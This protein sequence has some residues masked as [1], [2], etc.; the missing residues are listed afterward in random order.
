MTLSVGIVCSDG[1]LLASDTLVEKTREFRYSSHLSKI[2]T[3]ANHVIAAACAGTE[4]APLAARLVVSEIDPGKFDSSTIIPELERTALKALRIEFGAIFDQLKEKGRA[5]QAKSLLLVATHGSI[6]R[7]EICSQPFV[8]RTFSG[9]E[10]AGDCTNAATFFLS[11]YLPELPAPRL[12]ND[13][14]LIATHFIRMGA[15]QNPT[16]V[17]GLELVEVTPNGIRKVPTDEVAALAAKSEQ[18]DSKI[19]AMFGI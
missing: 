16:Y 2:E 7:V 13:V 17:G 9:F 4:T 5:E 11:R 15:T 12:L 1:V 8:Q 3:S 14:R 18:I 19:K 6:Y 10:I